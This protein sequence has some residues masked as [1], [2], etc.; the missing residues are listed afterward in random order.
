MTQPKTTCKLCGRDVN[1]PRESG[2][3]GRCDDNRSVKV[4]CPSCL[5]YRTRKMVTIRKRKG[6]LHCASCAQRN[7]YHG[8]KIPAVRTCEQCGAAVFLANAHAH[9][10]GL[11]KPCRIKNKKARSYARQQEK[12]AQAHRINKDQIEVNGCVLQQTASR[13]NVE[14]FLISRCPDWFDCKRMSACLDAVA[15]R[16]W[17]GFKRIEKNW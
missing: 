10:G 2:L 8:K 1:N 6:D 11:C 9:W 13:I 3:C 5:R 17:I 7:H 4:R 14:G 15:S 16:N 12:L